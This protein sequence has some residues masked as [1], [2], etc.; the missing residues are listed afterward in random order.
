MT[1]NN[2]NHPLATPITSAGNWGFLTEDNITAYLD[3][4]YAGRLYE[5]LK[6][7]YPGKDIILNLVDFYAEISEII[8]WQENEFY[9]EA[10][11]AFPHLVSYVLETDLE[12]NGLY[13]VSRIVSNFLD[14]ENENGPEHL[15]A[16]RTTV[17]NLSAMFQQEKYKNA[18]YAALLDKSRSD[19]YEL[20]S[21]ANGFY[22]EDY[23]E[24]FFSY[25][26]HRPLQ[27]LYWSYWTFEMDE[28][29]CQRFIEWARSYMPT[30]S[31]G[32]RVCRTR[33]YNETEKAVLE[34]VLSYP[35][36]TLRN[37]QDRHDFLIWGL[38]STHKFLPCNAAWLLEDMPLSEWPDGS[39][40]IIKEL[41]DKMEP[42]WTS[43]IRK[44]SRYTTIK[45]RLSILLQKE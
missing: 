15:E 39:I 19:Y 24:L 20:I 42:N 37:R 5:T 25:A 11:R 3:L 16:L 17:Q 14:D 44:E 21:M 34:R 18:I 41:F 4:L 1:P 8:F 22:D 45:E 23:F 12:I 26:Q 35:D 32:K 28:A 9:D 40:E 7:G 6:T 10:L 30:D 13:N 43:W 29:Q 38:S 31:L 27:G 36:H 33:Q 2:S